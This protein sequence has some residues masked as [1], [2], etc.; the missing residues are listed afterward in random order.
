MGNSSSDQT[1]VQLEEE[2]AAAKPSSFSSLLSSSLPSTATESTQNR[3]QINRSFSWDGVVDRVNRN[4]ERVTRSLSC[5]L[6]HNIDN[7]RQPNN[8]SRSRPWCRVS[9]KGWH[10]STLA[11]E[12]LLSKTC[13]PVSSAEA[14][15]LPHFTVD[16]NAERNYTILEHIAN[17]AFGKVYKVQKTSGEERTLYA[18]KVLSKSEIINSGAIGQLK[19]EVD[20]Q[21]V[22][23]HHPFLA[24]CLRYWQNKKKIFL[25]SF[26]YPNGELFQKIV[27]FPLEL[28]RLYVAEI[29]LAL[30]FLHQAGIIHRD[31]KPE[32][33]L[34][35]QDYHIRLIDFGLSKWLRIGSRTHTLCGT[36][37]Y[38][39]PEILSREPYGH[40]IDWWALGVLA[41]RMY[42]GEYPCLDLSSYL[43]KFNDVDELIEHG[44]MREWS[45][46]KSFIPESVATL[47]GE[48]QDLLKRLLETKPQYRLRSVLQL[49][50]IAL[51]RNFNWDDVRN[52]KVS[53][54]Q[55]IIASST[56][57]VGSGDGDQ[58]TGESFEEFDW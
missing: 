9:R 22:C 15:F 4:I 24:Q 35:D 41:C 43:N 2:A 5:T 56:A 12:H 49:Q 52:K 54:R 37:Q 8:S 21:T 25:L 28:V 47:P 27:H 29:A 38:M 55:I 33:I 39:A 6:H 58:G 45:T 48:A 23:G 36:L 1:V 10:E 50:R 30:D 16:C 40:A 14:L 17:G 51:Y 26:F 11:D 57:I 42:I 44:K 7:V 13:W 19:D 18:L 32:N 20:I 31:L 3:R 34:L 46:S 53:P